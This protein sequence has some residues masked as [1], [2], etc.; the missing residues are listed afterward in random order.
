MNI[1]PLASY[2][3]WL[4]GVIIS[5][6]AIWVSLY[7]KSQNISCSYGTVSC[8]EF[9]NTLDAFVRGLYIFSIIGVSLFLLVLPEY[10]FK[11]WRW[12]A[13]ISVPI[14]TWWITTAVGEFFG[15][16]TASYFSGIFFL[17]ASILIAIF[18]SIYNYFKIR[19]AK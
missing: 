6:V 12:F 14:L 9:I 1:F 8:I 4:L 5:S 13:I 15:H 3:K 18:A 11:L 7:L 16:I 17:S 2:R 19:K 10:I